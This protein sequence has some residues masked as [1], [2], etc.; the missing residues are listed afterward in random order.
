MQRHE[1]EAADAAARAA[2]ARYERLFDDFAAAWNGSFASVEN[3]K[4]CQANPFK[5]VGARAR[6]RAE[7]S[8][9][10]GR[11]GRG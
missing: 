6:A 9:A 10:R 7:K 11:A 2:R 3:L 1:R 4:E 8:R 5:T